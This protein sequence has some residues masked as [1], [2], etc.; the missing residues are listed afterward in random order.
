MLFL[1]HYVRNITMKKCILEP[2]NDRS[3]KR[4]E[5]PLAGLCDLSFDWASVMKHHSTSASCTPNIENPL[6][7]LINYKPKNWS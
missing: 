5:R 3:C 4:R 2:T 6:N 7:F 1:F